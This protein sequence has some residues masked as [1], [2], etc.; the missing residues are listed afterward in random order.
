MGNKKGCTT[1]NKGKTSIYSEETLEKMRAKKIGKKLSKRIKAQ[2]CLDY[3][4]TA[5]LEDAGFTVIRLPEHE[6]REM[7]EDKFKERLIVA[8]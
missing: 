8:C 5:Q 2:R 3:E 4:R 6:I 1:W 7:D